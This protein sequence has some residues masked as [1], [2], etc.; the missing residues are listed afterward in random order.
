[1]PV[2]IQ[3]LTKHDV[4]R[5]MD[6][7]LLYPEWQDK[8][9]LAGCEDVKKYKF[10]AYYVLP[11]W[12]PLVVSEIG[13]FAKEN[14]IEIGTGISF[15]FG[16]ATT[17]AKLAESEDQIKIGATVLDMVANVAWLKDKKYDLYQKEC[18]AFVKLCHD[19]GLVAKIII[20]VGFLS[21]EE[22]VAAV[23]MVSEAGA[24]FVKTA[25]GQG[26]QGRPNFNDAKLILKTL[27]DLN[28]TTKLKVSGVVAPRILNAYSFIRLGAARI[29]TRGAVQVVEALPE[30]Q[31]ML[32]PD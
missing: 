21:E 28:S 27:E 30:V 13:E 25:T 1:M 4:A 32:Y 20:R 11:H 5:M 7:A 14:K 26:P 8:Q 16:S 10:V 31:R 24:E 22:T 17:A 15:P 2:S 19:A 6:Y 12:V 3:N 18:S 9:T 23:K 29:G